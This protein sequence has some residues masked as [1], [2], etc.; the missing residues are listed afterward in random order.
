MP[1]THVG[2]KMK[3]FVLKPSLKDA[4]GEA[5]LAAML[6]YADRIRPENPQLACDLRLWASEI[7]A[8]H[9]R[10]LGPTLSGGPDV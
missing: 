2:L 8:D 7:E 1:D 5:S 3:Y 6:E 10:S 4:Y 9:Y